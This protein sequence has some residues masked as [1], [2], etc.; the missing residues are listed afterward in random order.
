MFN[1]IGPGNWLLPFSVRCML[2]AVIAMSQLTLASLSFAQGAV[3]VIVMNGKGSGTYS[4]GQPIQITA[5]PA[6]SGFQFSRW[7]VFGASA[8]S[9]VSPQT[10]LTPAPSAQTIVAIAQTVPTPTPDSLYPLTVSG[11]TGSGS[12]KAGAKVNISAAPASGN[13]VF[14][15][16]YDALGILADPKS[17]ATTATIPAASA[18][19]L[20]VYTASN[21]PSVSVTVTGGTIKGGSTSGTYKVGEVLTIVANPPAAGKVFDKW[22]GTTSG[23]A[24]PAQSTTTLTVPNSAVAVAASYKDSTTADVKITVSSGVVVNPTSSGNY[25]PGSTITIRA[26]PPAAGKA[27]D[28]WTATAGTLA[29]AAASETAYT[30]PSTAATVTAV[31]KDTAPSNT[32]TAVTLSSHKPGDTISFQGETIVG[33]VRAPSTV[34][35]LE[36]TL[37]TNGRKSALSIDKAN[38]NF[39]MR[40]FEGDVGNGKSVTV[41]FNRTDTSGAK[42]T[43][44]FQFTAVAE[45]ASPQMI[46]SRLTFGATPALVKQ[47]NATTFE[48]WVEQQL[49]PEKIDDSAFQAMKPDTIVPSSGYI[50]GK[51]VDWQVAYAAYSQRQLLEVMTM[52]WDNHFWSTNTNA[53]LQSSDVEEIKGF[54]K[55]AL[56]RFRD[57]LAVSSKSPQMLEFLD[58]VA[59]DA[60]G[61]NQNYARELFELHTV[62]VNGGYTTDDVNGAARAFSGWN[63]VQTSAKDVLPAT[64]AF[65]F[66]PSR[67]IVKDE[68]VIKYLGLSFP[69]KST[70][71]DADITEGEQILDKLA[72]MPQTQEFVCGKIVEKLVSDDRPRSLIDKCKSAWQSSGG[73]I[74]QSLRA[75]LLDPSYLTELKFQRSKAKTPFEAG[76]AL[77]RNLAIMP[78]AGREQD[79]Y[80]YFSGAAKS[81]GMDM[82]AFNVPTGFKEIGSQW[83]NTASLNSKYRN[84]GKMASGIFTATTSGNRFGITNYTQLIKDSGMS[85]AEAAAAY[86]LQLTT[87]DRYRMDEFDA[88]VTALKD[89]KGFDIADPKAE[90]R[91]AKAL[92]LITALP[93]TQ[94]Q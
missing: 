93:S 22:T 25:K 65:Q 40:L 64:Y 24:D 69:V 16:W 33:N 28:R 75:I 43:S 72:M 94:L 68:R 34:A 1:A 80:G 61:F 15:Y 56:G 10:I 42:E 26:N 5:E 41:T 63:Y 84:L 67:H 83:T 54:R 12:Y 35:A 6:Q 30:V 39:A 27:F 20:A 91:L 73:V 58:N 18:Y 47:L 44:A 49:N 45:K 57:L 2:L 53:K 76:V 62:G 38:G 81:A 59:S 55:H 78:F 88:V 46:A 86:L 77:I 36:A 71:V 90:E 50:E 11:G 89:T 60:N 51:Y 14:S 52:F 32:G 66:N 82:P 9:L 85:S 37:S 48:A 13:K 19:V 87:A 74:A 7:V 3:T 8:G 31:Y 92:I 23:L 4:A 21:S 17:A 70:A 79:F 29:N